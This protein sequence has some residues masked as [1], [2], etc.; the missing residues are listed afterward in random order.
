MSSADLFLFLAISNDSRWLIY[1]LWSWYGPKV[2][3]KSTWYKF[4]FVS[5]ETLNYF[6][7][8]GKIIAPLLLTRNV[9]F[10]FDDCSSPCDTCAAEF[11]WCCTNWGTKSTTRPF[12]DWSCGKGLFFSAF[13]PIF[14]ASI[15]H[16]V[17]L[18]HAKS[19]KASHWPRD[20]I[21]PPPLAVCL[22]RENVCRRRWRLEGVWEEV[23]GGVGGVEGD[24][25]GG[26]SSLILVIKVESKSEGS[27]I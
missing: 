24:G 23:F 20:T 26:S 16:K 22:A 12:I 13:P 9:L 10:C 5:M 15:L 27:H 7:V 2:I 21:D 1:T 18:W 25:G 6:S 3:N 4:S 8:K 19:A 14:D 17:W 11:P